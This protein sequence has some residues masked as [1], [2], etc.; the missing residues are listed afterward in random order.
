MND[1]PFDWNS[2]EQEFELYTAVAQIQEVLDELNILMTTDIT[3]A[4]RGVSSGIDA[5]KKLADLA[6]KTQNIELREGILNLREQ[7]LEAK[8]ALLDA[9]EQVSSYKQENTALKTENEKLKEELEKGQEKKFYLSD[10]G[11]YYTEDAF[12]DGPFCTACYDSERK[13][14][15]VSETPVALQALGKYKCPVCKAPY[16]GKRSY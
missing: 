14:I 7:L 12:N 4:I 16:S 9:K 10:D 15:R 13:A 3:T 8:D 11:L 2:Y 6:V 5:V 1:Q